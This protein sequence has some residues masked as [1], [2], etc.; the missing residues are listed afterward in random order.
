MDIARN[1]LYAFL[2][3]LCLVGYVWLLLSIQNHAMP[4]VFKGC[5]VKQL[6]TIPCPACGTTRA[7]VYLIR[8]NY[9]KALWMNPLGFVVII[10]MAVLPI[11]ITYDVLTK[12]NSL[13]IFYYQLPNYLKKTT[14][15]NLLIILIIINWIWNIIKSI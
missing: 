5:L 1:K 9:V 8:G 12:K 3:S 7:I 4:I 11:W 2:M 15:A 10:I 14:L 13:Y 6:L